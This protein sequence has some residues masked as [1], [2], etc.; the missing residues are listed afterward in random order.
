[1]LSCRVLPLLPPARSLSPSARPQVKALRE[2]MGR[3]EAE[4]GASAAAVEDREREIER[5]RQALDI[6]AEEFT[7]K[8][9]AAIKAQ[10]LYNVTQARAF[11]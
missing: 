6:H 1:M 2:K 9:G 4:A 3:L 8:S 7:G 5:L 11:V 10:L